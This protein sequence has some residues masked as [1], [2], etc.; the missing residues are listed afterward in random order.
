MS[1]DFKDLTQRAQRNKDHK[2]G[3]RG[4]RPKIILEL[5]DKIAD[6]NP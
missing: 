2:E 4:F 1:I 6:K 3:R 5:H